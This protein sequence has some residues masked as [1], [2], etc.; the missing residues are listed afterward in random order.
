MFCANCGN[1]LADG[2][3]FCSGCG[4]KVGNIAEVKQAASYDSVPQAATVYFEQG[5]EYLA[6]KDSKNAANAFNAAIKIAPNYYE[7]KKELVKIYSLSDKN[8]IAIDLLDKMLIERPDDSEAFFLRAELYIKLDQLDKALM[9]LNIAKKMNPGLHEIYGAF[10]R[11]YTFQNDNKKVIENYTEAIKLNSKIFKYYLGRGN[12]YFSAN[13]LDKAIEDYSKVLSLNKNNEESLYKRGMS[14]FKLNKYDDAL[15]DFNKLLSIN[16]EDID[17]L[18]I[19]G[20]ICFFKEDYKKAIS[21]FGYCMTIMNKTGE[22]NNLEYFE[23]HAMSCIKVK[24]FKE[25]REDYIN[26][27][28]INPNY[29]FQDIS[30]FIDGLAGYYEEELGKNKLDKKTFLLVGR[31]GSNN[32]K[33]GEFVDISGVKENVSGGKR[34]S[35]LY[36]YPIMFFCEEHAKDF[37]DTPWTSW[38]RENNYPVREA[39]Y[40]YQKENERIRKTPIERRYSL[41][42]RGQYKIIQNKFNE[43]PSFW[44]IISMPS[45]RIYNKNKKGKI[46]FEYPDKGYPTEDKNSLFNTIEEAI[47]H[48]KEL[49]KTCFEDGTRCDNYFIA[50]TYNKETLAA[51]KAANPTHKASD[52]FITSAVCRTLGKDDNCS[53]LILFRNFRDTYMCGSYEKIAEVKEYY[54]IAPKICKNIETTEDYG[55]IV[56]KYIWN[57]YLKN[58]LRALNNNELDKAY[59]IYKKMVLDLKYNYIFEEKE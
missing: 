44:F 58:A 18:G 22:Y 45:G 38:L 2:S 29:Q 51:L 35:T 41:P 34:L 13:M 6:Q 50:G 8:K 40:R 39:D 14:L 9:D 48:Y 20:K 54:N 49:I 42:E 3:K 19:H 36:F 12:A 52:C 21:S 46:T 4:T 27:I 28:D 30:C 43:A 1:M 25:V 55:N 16:Q 10:G 56:Y 5:I 24:K 47:L 32:Q 33:E 59:M 26:I 37:S 17:Y 57:N 15:A 7:A 11:I 31:K 23:F 53:E